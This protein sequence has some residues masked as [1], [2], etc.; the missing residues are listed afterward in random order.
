MIRPHL[1][2]AQQMHRD[3]PDTFDVPTKDELRKIDIHQYVKVSNG[4]ERFWVQICDKLT[5]GYFRG[6]VMNRLIFFTNYTIGDV[7]Q[8]HERHIYNILDS[9]PNL[10]STRESAAQTLSGFIRS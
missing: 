1:I 4:K 2:N 3:Y 7:I 8:F 9:V 6:V 10:T 5:R